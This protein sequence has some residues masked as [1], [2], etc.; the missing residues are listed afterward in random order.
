MASN[1]DGCQPGNSVVIDFYAY[2]DF[3]VQPDYGI[4]LEVVDTGSTPRTLNAISFFRPQVNAFGLQRPP[5]GL[6]N[7]LIKVKGIPAAPVT[8]CEFY[9]LDA[10]G[11]SDCAVMLE[12]AFFTHVVIAVVVAAYNNYVLRLKNG[13]NT[14]AVSMVPDVNVDM[15]APSWPSMLVGFAKTPFKDRRP[16]GFYWDES[17]RSTSLQFDLNDHGYQQPENTGY[18]KSNR[19]NIAD[20]I[21]GESAGRTLMPGIGG[22]IQVPNITTVTFTLPDANTY[23]GLTFTFVKTSANAQPVIIQGMVGQTINGKA[24]NSEI[25]AQYDT[26]TAR[27]IGGIWIITAKQI[28]P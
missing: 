4:M 8:S 1:H 14:Y 26:I 20:Q 3:G 24:L 10:E 9:G 28:A 12:N 13:R 25:K 7:A 21:D 5:Q 27:A 11:G 17:T 15:D 19:L 23:E 2:L 22:T 18:L 16:F 6:N